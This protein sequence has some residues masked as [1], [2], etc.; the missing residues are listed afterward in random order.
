[1]T[2]DSRSAPCGADSGC[3]QEFEPK[4][5]TVQPGSADLCVLTKDDVSEVRERLLKANVEIVDLGSEAADDGTVMRIGAR[6]KL[7]SVY[8]RDSDGNLIE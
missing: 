6:C 8:C 2:L 4:A 1:M 3:D 7:R 5:R